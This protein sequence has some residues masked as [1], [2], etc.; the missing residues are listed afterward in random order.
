MARLYAGPRTTRNR[1]DGAVSGE[2]M[3]HPAL[4]EF[5]NRIRDRPH[6]RYDRWS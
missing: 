2:R 3:L 6:D 4:S 1:P 5:H